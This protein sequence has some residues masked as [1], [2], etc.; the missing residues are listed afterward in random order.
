MVYFKKSV[1]AALLLS[2]PIAVA[3][4]VGKSNCNLQ[5]NAAVPVAGSGVVGTLAGTNVNA[6]CYQ[7]NACCCCDKLLMWKNTT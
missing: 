5:N 2:L 4:L 3:S 1:V 7:V 6:H